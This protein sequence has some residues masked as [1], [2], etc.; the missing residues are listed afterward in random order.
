M[1][2]LHFDDEDIEIGYVSIT[3]PIY[4][5]YILQLPYMKEGR[6][7]AEVDFKEFFKQL[8]KLDPKFL[9]T[10]LY[11][12]IHTRH[13]EYKLKGKQIELLDL[14]SPNF[15]N[16]LPKY[17]NNLMVFMPFVGLSN[18]DKNIISDLWG[19]FEGSSLFIFPTHQSISKSY[20]YVNDE[21][22]ILLGDL[23]DTLYS[24][25]KEKLSKEKEVYHLIEVFYYK[26]KYA[27]A[28]SQLIEQY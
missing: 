17:I 25:A 15:T 7:E 6:N 20:Q 10:F 22:V 19:N 27:I 18:D 21:N 24:L 12:K 28:L 14:S 3:G 2:L 4:W 11:S 5:D 23:M 13:P 9:T 1:G 8:R 26:V 16:Y